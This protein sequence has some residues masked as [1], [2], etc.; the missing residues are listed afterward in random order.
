MGLGATDQSRSLFLKGF[1]LSKQGN[2]EDPTYLGFKIVVDFGTLPVNA[3]DGL[4][5]SPLFRPRS[6]LVGTEN[7][8]FG[9]NPFG[10]PQY[11]YVTPGDEGYVGYYSAASFLNQREFDFSYGPRRGDMLLQFRAMFSDM[12]TNYPWFIQAIGGLD[13]L[14]KVARP[15]YQ[16]A[17]DASGFTPQRT[18]GKTLD[19]T[20]LESLN[21]RMSAMADLYNQA[22][23][24][25]DN[26]RELLPRNLRKFTMW[27][28]V[29]EIRNFFQ[30]SRLIGSSASLVSL[31]NLSNLLLAG[32]NP[33]SS[34]GLSSSVAN[35]QN[36]TYFNS[37][38]SPGS[39]F[40]SFVSNIVDQSGLDSDFSLL[41]N[42]Q[43]QNGIKPIMV[44]ECRNCEFDFT[45]STPIS[46]ETTVGSGAATP[47]TQKF[48]IH[49]GK[50]RV[51]NQYPNIRQD[52]K[53][54]VLGDSWD[55][56]RSSV[57]AGDQDPGSLLSLGGQLLTNFISNSL[58][59]LIN[60][61]IQSFV[62][63]N[64]QG[65]NQF[66]LGNAYS[67]NPSQIL[68][69]LNFNNAQNFL[70]SLSGVGVNSGTLNLPNPQSTGLGGPPQRVYAEPQGDV[71]AQVPGRDL[72]VPE[73]V[74]GEPR[75]DVYAQVP[76]R[77]L[78]VPERVYDEPRGDV[79]ANVPGPDLGVPD[80]V[81]NEPT[82]DVYA[83]VPGSDLGS[84]D[85]VYSEPRGDVY[86]NVPGSDLGSPER[87]Y[88]EVRD[89]VYANVPGSDLGSPG[90]VYGEVR[91]DVYANV[92]GRDLGVP[93][94]V[95]EDFI[96]DV[97]NQNPISNELKGV[98][99][100]YNDLTQEPKLGSQDVYAEDVYSQASNL[101]DTVYQ[102]RSLVYSPGDELRSPENR[103]ESTPA[104]V[105]SPAA[106]PR[107]RGNLGDV[108][109]PVSGEFLP[110]RPI[111]L[112]NAKAETK[113]NIST[114]QY[115]DS[116]TEFL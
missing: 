69:N 28:F 80:R 83:N 100:V 8:F 14:A 55:A 116:K 54:L 22:T 72:G 114:G 108:Y 12:L 99:K 17:G 52:G 46:S 44:F 61:G 63:P 70:E 6:Y 73:R 9:Q 35:N 37:T 40:N 81:Y 93:N 23:F 105:Y 79:Y 58:N 65:L 27:I 95:Y 41:R 104:P 71:Y 32:N 33:G 106:R 49:V 10:Q 15:G 87:V 66:V 74:Y 109:P 3:D 84:P 111:D 31:N 25:Y 45:D 48:K 60:E 113:F 7:T 4:P 19:F 16:P 98:N 51:R 20:T 24:D 89:D 11:N 102:Q 13:N 64:L 1:R 21:L 77:D 112:G 82:G 43:D 34:L 39:A 53:P 68:A 26:M 67:L 18:Q 57:Q 76:G 2:Y 86:A 85:R 47:A 75:G 36:Q 50:V 42:Q 97:Y 115:N 96:S 38:T 56:S 94:R 90:R 91:D 59:D 78:G 29:S 30:T 101:N 88:G 62:T 107:P 92:P 5:P 110:E 103:F